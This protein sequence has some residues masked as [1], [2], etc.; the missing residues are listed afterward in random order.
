MEIVPKS[1]PQQTNVHET[2]TRMNAVSALKAALTHARTRVSRQTPSVLVT[3]LL[4]DL[5]GVGQDRRRR[6]LPCMGEA[7][8]I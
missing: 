8:A 6:P 1:W 2:R 5:Q 7:Q 4:N 3:H